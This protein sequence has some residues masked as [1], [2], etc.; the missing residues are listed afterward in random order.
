MY[1]LPGAQGLLKFDAFESLLWTLRKRLRNDMTWPSDWKEGCRAV[2]KYFEKSPH[3]TVKEWAPWGNFELDK[4]VL[5][6][7]LK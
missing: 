2:R 4:K 6:D 3:A 7:Y 1:P 5:E